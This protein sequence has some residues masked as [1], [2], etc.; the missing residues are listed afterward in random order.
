[1]AGERTYD[2]PAARAQQFYES[3]AKALLFRIDRKISL[4][5][6]MNLIF[7]EQGQDQTRVT[8]NT[9]YVVVKDLTIY[10][11]GYP[12]PVHKNESIF[13]NSG[14][15]AAFTPAGEFTMTCRPNGKFENDVLGLIKGR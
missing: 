4:E 8:A 1:M 2:L 3:T 9:R 5:G 10:Q 11:V 15:E 12:V 14:Q 7:E 13:F 6:R